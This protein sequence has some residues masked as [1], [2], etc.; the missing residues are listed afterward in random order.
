MFVISGFIR[1][2]SINRMID[3]QKK[4]SLMDESAYLGSVTAYSYWLKP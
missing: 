2:Y 4:D 3:P 1:K